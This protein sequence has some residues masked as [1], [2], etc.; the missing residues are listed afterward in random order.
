MQ[1][2]IN[3]PNY[4]RFADPRMLVDSARLAEAAGWDGFFVWDHLLAGDEDVGDT[5]IALAAMAMSTSRIRLGPMVT[6][7]PRRRPWKLAREA[8][9]LDHL[10]GGRLTLGLGLGDDARGEY[11]A[12]GEPEEAQEHAEMLEEGLEVLQGLWSGER[13]RFDG[14]HYEVKG[15]RF[16]PRPVQPHI[17]IWLAGGWP[18]RRPFRRAARWDGVA[19]IRRDRPLTPEECRAVYD[20][21]RGERTS[22]EPFDLAVAVWPAERSRVEEVELAGEYARAGA[23]WYQVALSA[24]MGPAQVHDVIA[25]G[26]P[27][28]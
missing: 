18:S 3:T 21:L 19:P 8:V 24:D 22:G 23:T 7:L 15:A 20:F 16:L 26:P 5:W 9:T 6:P 10:S 1:F 11:S 25:A 4:G 14:K 2:A 12:F 13:F 28:V 27:R 17:P